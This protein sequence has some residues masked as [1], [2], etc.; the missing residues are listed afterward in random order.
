MNA[1]IDNTLKFKNI[2]FSNHILLLIRKD[3]EISIIKDN[4]KYQ[5]NNDSIVFI[6]K[7]QH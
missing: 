6:K 3:S 7:I 1:Y 4:V 2:I 5:V